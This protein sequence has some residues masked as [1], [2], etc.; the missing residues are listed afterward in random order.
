VA[1][2]CQDDVDFQLLQRVLPLV[3]AWSVFEM[4]LLTQDGKRKSREG[5]ERLEIKGLIATAKTG[6]LLHKNNIQ[7][8]D[9]NH[10][11]PRTLRPK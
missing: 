4:I 10:P 7:L 5:E 1:A 8:D 6:F 2:R 9:L 3:V 11:P